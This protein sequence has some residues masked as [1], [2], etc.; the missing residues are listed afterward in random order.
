MF[1]PYVNELPFK[2]SYKTNF[3]KSEFIRETN[4]YD[5]ICLI[6]ALHHILNPEEVINKVY[7]SLK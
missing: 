1:E 7:H 6:T 5:C 2:T 4:R 3:Y